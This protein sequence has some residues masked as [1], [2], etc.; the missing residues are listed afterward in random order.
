MSTDAGSALVVQL[1]RLINATPEQVWQHCAVGI[2]E[3]LGPLTFDPTP[4]GRWVMDVQMGD[5]RYVMYGN[6]VA[7]DAPREVSFTWNEVDVATHTVPVHDTR[8]TISLTPQ[9]GGTLVTL[10]HEGF[11]ALPNAEQQYRNYKEGWESLNDL[12]NLAKLVE[13]AL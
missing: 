7:F 13:G 12:E 1:Q 10:R 3:W 9:D 11:E 6:V 5:A 8:V 2:K 4:G